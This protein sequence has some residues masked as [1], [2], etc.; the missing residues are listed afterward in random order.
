MNDG[1]KGAKESHDVA[2]EQQACR[3]QANSEM[4]KAFVFEKARALRAADAPTLDQLVKEST[5][6]IADA[7]PKGRDAA[8]NVAICQGR[9]VVALPSS[10][11]DPFGGS[12][13]LAAQIDFAV[14]STAGGQPFVYPIRGIDPI[15]YRLAA[16]NLPRGQVVPGASGPA[17]P[18]RVETAQVAPRPAAAASVGPVRPVPIRT[19]VRNKEPP[20]M[21]GGVA[22]EPRLTGRGRPSFNCRYARS[23]DERAV[24]GD[25]RLAALDRVAASLYRNAHA[26]GG[27]YERAAL[28]D[29]RDRL[30]ARRR[31]CD[32]AACIAAAYRDNMDRIDEIMS[33]D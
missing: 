29:A 14:Q 13:Q 8:L 30:I 2:Q 11:A 20:R 22:P 27:R 19:S 24:C 21:R 10:A 32:N 3:S 28:S 26:Q 18:N 7:L 33:R 6:Q 9:M 4:L 1:A 15:V 25:E 23:R 17:P 16:I 12:H 31:R 5:V